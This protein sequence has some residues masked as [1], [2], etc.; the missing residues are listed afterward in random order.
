MTKTDEEIINES[1]KCSKMYVEC[2]KEAIEKA[3]ASEREKVAKEILELICPEHNRTSCSDT[4]TQNGLYSNDSY[5]RC[6]RC[7]LLEII[8]LNKIPKSHSCNISF[9]IDDKIADK[10]DKQKYLGNKV[11]E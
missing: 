2:I 1:L 5:T 3:R 10:E 11:I 4:D 9:Y 7:T 8:K 6:A